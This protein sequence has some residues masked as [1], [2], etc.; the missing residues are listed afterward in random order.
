MRA[1]FPSL[2]AIA[3]AVSVSGCYTQVK[4]NGWPSASR[5]DIR[6]VPSEPAFLAPPVA[7]APV[8]DDT[9]LRGEFI[10]T[11]QYDFTPENA[12]ERTYSGDISF[13]L[14]EGMYRCEGTLIV[15][16]GRFKDQGNEIVFDPPLPLPPAE[17]PQHWVATGK[18]GISRFA[19]EHREG[20][21]HL[22]SRDESQQTS[23]E[24]VLRRLFASR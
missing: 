16:R 5:P 15:E 6:P 9:V 2:A 13:R 20:A 19:V 8:V 3:I 21:W 23:C 10:G 4:T 24:I 17:R 1:L 11:I 22:T 12:D 18:S 14:Q 7:H